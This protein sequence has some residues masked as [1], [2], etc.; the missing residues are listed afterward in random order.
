MKSSAYLIN[1]SRGGIVDE[2][3][4]YKAL[5]KGKIAGAALDVYENEPPKQSPL[6]KLE[7]AVFT[8][9]IGAA[10]TEGQIRA[11]VIC[12]EQILKVLD[13]DEPDFWVNKN[14][15]KS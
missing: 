14:M 8:P 11:G 15:M 4:L 12:A 7:N 5:E 6:L 3:A 13:G 2:K 10:T 1:C 9:H